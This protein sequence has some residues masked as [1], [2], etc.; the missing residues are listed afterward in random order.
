[1]FHSPI[2]SW[3]VRILFVGALLC[4]ALPARAIEWSTLFT[5]Q[6]VRDHLSTAQGRAEALEFCKKMGITKVYIEEFRDG[7]Q[8]D[9]ETLKT[10]RDFFRNAGLKVS[11]CVTTT[12]LGKPSTGWHVAVCY[13]HRGNQEKLESVFRFAAGLLDEIM[14]DDF[15]FTDCE[16]SECAAA[17]GAMSWPQYRDKLMVEMSRERVLGPARQVNPKV[18]IILK[19]PQW[20]DNFQ[21]RGYVVDKETSLYDRIW[22]GTETRDPSSDEWGHKQQY[23]GFFIYRWLS[24]IGGAKTGGAWFDPYGTNP[25]TYLDQ[26]VTSVLAGPPEIFLF[27]YGSLLSPDFR[28][29]AEAFA[30]HRAELESLAKYTADW[31][32]IPAYKPISSDPG[33]EEYIYD[34]IGMLGI[35]LMPTARFPE[36]AR[37]A[38]FT[39]HALHDVEFVPELT[40]FLKAGGTAFLSQELAHRLSAD[41]RLPA[42]GSLDL[43]K[44]QYVKTLEAGEGK[45][46]IFSDALPKLA[47]VDSQNRVAQ[48]TETEWAALNDLRKA[49]ADFTMTSFDAPPR[50]AVYPLG[51]RVAVVNYTELPVACHLEGMAG[52]ARRYTKVFATSGAL[53]S[54]DR[55]T[56]RL[57]P[58]T[59]LIVE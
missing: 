25:T 58:H 48:P 17:K 27:H 1:M 42:K 50:V 13:T 41:P 18:K 9:A 34:S 55:A 12:G 45:L 39:A 54:S 7:Y 10:A 22:V 40:R 53:L 37:A 14:I 19:Y 3:W 5:A 16:C 6:D 11:G 57:P 20:Y 24:E 30:Q 8:A 51:G 49:V 33:Q 23:E 56:L 21:N 29:Q 44:E 38:L 26:A 2:R 47:Y 28:A 43:E 36:G 32:G 4:I 31:G 52:M 15:F 46:V 59:L 35:P